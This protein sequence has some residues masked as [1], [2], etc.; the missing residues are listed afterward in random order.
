M[1][2]IRW[3][4]AHPDDQLGT[5]G[6]V[7]Y[8][9]EPTAREHAG[10]TGTVWALVPPEVVRVLEAAVEW[11]DA[12]PGSSQYQRAADALDAAV[13]A[14]RLAAPA[15]SEPTPDQPTT[16]ARPPA[17][18]DAGGLSGVVAAEPDGGPWCCDTC[19]RIAEAA[20]P[21]GPG[22]ISGRTPDVQP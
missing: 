18:G 9:D 5:G 20:N 19:R 8:P 21:L 14:A 12:A 17:S 7:A 22:E 6:W 13:D 11:R 15:A 10:T 1:T 3:L 16:E 2:P 4:V